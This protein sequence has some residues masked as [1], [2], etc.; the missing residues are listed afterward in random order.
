MSIAVTGATGHLG[1]LVVEH[2]LAG[3]VAPGEVVALG[4][5]QD[6][7]D[8]LATQGVRT[9]VAP[10]E[11]A[12]A[13][14]RALDGVETLVL[15]SGSEVGKRVEQ[16]R[17]AIDAAKAAGVTR[18]VYT[19]APHADTSTLV[20]VP[21]HKA[22]EELLRESGLAVVVLRNNWYTE[23]Y[24]GTVQ[25]AAQTGV[26]LGSTHGGRVASASRTDY[27]EAAAVVARGGHD[28]RTYELSGDVAWSYDDLAAAASE[29]L[30]RPVEHRDLSADEHRAALVA[31]G[32]DEG[33]AGFV[34]QMD[35][36][37]ANGDL[38]DAT[39]SLRELVGRPTTPLVDGLRAALS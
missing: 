27:A 15:V 8:E 10:Y 35:A 4:R 26:I 32:L 11:D 6:R 37:T 39:T 16:H 31:A 38:A 13:L 9:A 33:T 36:D 25:Q 20:V 24:V 23:N 3:G 14:R 1:R 22:T 5:R 28:G 2:L 12:D 21:E 34:V 30:G 17:A 29:L 18:V 19:S 7:L